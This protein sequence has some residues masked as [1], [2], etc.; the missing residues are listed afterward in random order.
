MQTF[1]VIL[2]FGA[3]CTY[4]GKQLYKTFW[5]KEQQCEGCSVSHLHQKNTS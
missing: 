5:Q 2:T 4:L 1:L 3:A